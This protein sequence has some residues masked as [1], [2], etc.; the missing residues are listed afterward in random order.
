M[1][2][3]EPWG[4]FC[5]RRRQLYLGISPGLDRK[6]PCP[7]LLAIAMT[8]TDVVIFVIYALVV[9]FVVVKM[10][11]ELD[12]LV[13]IKPQKEALADQLQ[14]W[15]LQDS[16][17]LSFK[18]PKDIGF[19]QLDRL[20]ISIDNRSSDRTFYLN[21]AQSSLGD[22]KGMAQGV[23]RFLPGMYLNLSQEQ[24]FSVIPPQSK[25]CTHI[26]TERSLERDAQSGEFQPAKSL[27]EL[28][29][30]N[31]AVNSKKTFTLRLSLQEAPRADRLSGQIFL[32]DVP[33]QVEQIPWRKALVWRIRDEKGRK[34]KQ[35]EQKVHKRYR[36]NKN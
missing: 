33:F 21:W 7:P 31:T 23:V 28:H 15:G 12:S 34:K 2:S 6:N 16:L 36:L 22:F 25:L 5:D 3:G 11:A 10:M 24:A 17:K 18:F 26:T 13:T 29:Q 14:M 35:E 30:L 32:L 20:E 1:G 4:D 9:G 8:Q 19:K 27:F